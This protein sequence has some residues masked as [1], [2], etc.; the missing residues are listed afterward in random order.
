[1]TKQ[2]KR[3]VRRPKPASVLRVV[4]VGFGRLGGAIAI[5]LDQAKWPIAVFPR[6]GDAVRRAASFKIRLA[7]HD[8]L[9]EADLCLLAIPDASVG[10]VAELIEADLG[11]QTAL[12]HLSGALPLSIFANTKLPRA[13]GSFHPLVAVSDPRDDL[14]GHAVAI[15]S[16]SKPLKAQLMVL[17]NALGLSPIE[18]PETGRPAYHAGAVMSAGLMVSLA[19]AAV[20]ALEH[21]GLPREAAAKALLP[22]MKSALRGMESRGLEK[23]LTSCAE[24][25]EWCS[26]T[27]RRCRPS[28]A[29]C[30]AC[31]RVER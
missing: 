12:V 14:A 5:G 6:S 22:L 26:R 25:W 17:A 15:A 19:D 20:S 16:T 13:F 11:P 27:S 7:D 31:S 2:K 1:M 28:W 21:A 3:A 8:D 30:T 24:T 10:Q 9:R 23:G 18:V 29:A 4:V